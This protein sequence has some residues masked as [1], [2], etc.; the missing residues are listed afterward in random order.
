[1]RTNMGAMTAAPGATVPWL[2]APGVTTKEDAAAMPS[3]ALLN[4]PLLSALEKLWDA[5]PVQNVLPINWVEISKA[6]QTLWQRELSDPVS[7]MQ[8]ATDFNAKVWGAAF[9]SWQDAAN[10]FWGIRGRRVRKKRDVRTSVSPRRT[11]TRTPTTR[12]S[13]SLTC[14]PPSTS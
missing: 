14:S 12:R 1:M 3:G 4:D 8:R 11:G 5:N 2:A 6:L 13:R 9:E 7:A 10:R